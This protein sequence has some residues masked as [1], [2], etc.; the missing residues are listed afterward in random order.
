MRDRR[1]RRAT[2]A[3]CALLL[4]LL[5]SAPHV[6]QESPG[7]AAS[8][9]ALGYVVDPSV[10]PRLPESP[11]DAPLPL[12]VRLTAQWPEVERE[13]GV[14]DWSRYGGAIAALVESGHRVVL[15]LTGTHPLYLPAGGPPSPFEGDSLQAWVGFAR[16]A[17]REFGGRVE[18]FE[19]WDWV[20]PAD[21]T[22]LEPT[23]Y[24]FLLKN[25]AVAMRAE[26][27]AAGVSIGIAQASLASEGLEWQRELWARDVAAYID[28]LPVALRADSDATRLGEELRA[29][30]SENLLH[31]PAAAVWAYVDAAART[32]LWDGTTVALAALSSGVTRALVE[33]ESPSDAAVAPWIAAAHEALTAGGYAPAPRGA[34]DFEDATGAPLEGARVLGRFFSEEDFSTLIFYLAPGE[35]EEFPQ[36]RLI[37]DTSFVR[38][39]RILD[40]FTGRELRVPSS[41]LPDGAR[42]RSVRIGRS[43]HPQLLL[44]EQTAGTPGFALAPEEVGTE[45]ERELTAEEIIARYQQVQ[46]YQ[47]DRLERWTARGRVELHFNLTQGGG[48]TIDVSI[49]SNYF[50]ERGGELEWEQTDYRFNGNV[51]RWKRIP[52]LPQLQA[53]KVVTVPLDLTLGKTYA[54]RRVGTSRVG[55][56][57]AYVLAFEPIDPDTSLSLYRGRVWID[58]NTFV[59]L[60]MAVIQSNLEAPV[61]S[62][63]E[64]S[65]Y[66][67]WTGPDGHEY[68]MLTETDSQQLWKTMGRS[69]VVRRQ[70]A[71]SEIE[72]NLEREQFEGRRTTA[73]ASGNQMLRDTAEGFRYLD[74][75]TDGS[76]TV[77]DKIKSR[78]LFAAAGAFK[79]SSTDGI[80]PLAG[81]NYFNYNLRGKD[82][83]VNA[84]FAGVLGFFTLS[85]PNLFGGNNDAT[86]DAFLIGIKTEDKVFVGDDELETERIE[87]RNQNVTGRL[88]FP[89]GDFFRFTLFGGVTFRRYFDSDDAADAIERYNMDNPTQTLQFILPQDHDQYNGGIGAEFNRMGF[90][91]RA[92]ASLSKRSDWQVSGMFDSAAP[93]FVSFDPATGLYVPDDPEPVE[94]RFAR[95]RLTLFKEWYLPRFQRVRGEINY[96]NGSDLDRYSRYRFTLFGDTRLNGF[97]G[98][99]VRFDSGWVARAGYSFN[100]YEAVRFNATLE[101]AWVENDRTELGTESFTGIGLSGNVPGPWTTVISLGYGYALDSDVS[102]LKGEQEFLLFVFKLF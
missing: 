62:N 90:T 1:G 17:V 28:V 6:A 3:A 61:I 11:P 83:Q 50:W 85:D 94:D 15:C 102:E 101:S 33:L 71:F 26:A 35:A 36:D 58:R 24:A 72:I 21:R 27:R 76:R 91:L 99:G 52:Q 100:V 32:D 16:S 89:I 73:Y 56:R 78:Q 65:R 59:R 51:V 53:E 64:V 88:G 42:G 74:R 8:G 29:I 80:V 86:V 49:D 31:P 95:W 46:K 38:N 77:R 30:L 9:P 48:S 45:R 22:R 60:K 63:E 25:S 54:Y 7:D 43:A 57:E 81:F 10:V 68:W 34:L 19:I 70:L 97:S 66:S 2:I 13:A 55:K 39:A 84:L 4:A 79:D 75:Q 23:T 5:S 37:V 69:F 18:L 47:D 98:S 14:Y 92:D 93:G 12:T 67:P 87:Q 20:G 96:F 41:P 82:V 44:F 40:P